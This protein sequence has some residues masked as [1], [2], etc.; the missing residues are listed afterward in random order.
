MN[1]NEAKNSASVLEGR[2]TGEAQ[3]LIE[4]ASGGQIET[5]AALLAAGAHVNA[6]NYH[7]ETALLRAA[8]GGRVEA[9]NLLL[10][11]GADLDGTSADGMTALIRAALFG[12]VAAVGALLSRGANTAI[13][14]R[15]GS[16]ALD[17]ALSKGHDDVATLI[18]NN[19]SPVEEHVSSSASPAS[20]VWPEFSPAP[21]ALDLTTET[22]KEQTREAVEENETRS[23]NMTAET[24]P[25]EASE[26]PSLSAAATTKQTRPR[27]IVVDPETQFYHKKVSPPAAQAL[28]E[29][30]A[31]RSWPVVVTILLISFV[32]GAVLY[33]LSFGLPRPSL[34]RNNAAAPSPQQPT[35]IQ[36]TV[37]QVDNQSRNGDLS[38]PPN[39]ANANILPQQNTATDQDPTAPSTPLTQKKSAAR[40]ASQAG[41]QTLSSRPPTERSSTRA[42]ETRRTTAQQQPDKS[43]ASE[44]KSAPQQQQRPET[45][46]PPRVV[47]PVRDTPARTT[48]GGA[49]SG[50][51]APDFPEARKKKVIQ[52]P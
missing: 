45:P 44:S 36:P 16:T 27:M 15:F 43:V 5:I 35:Q 39:S 31:R 6:P 22:I 25:T 28:S 19:V 12:H 48:R 20:D 50:T 32:T 14:D 9:I 2:E 10:D 42:T 33:A 46:A 17:W 51:P 3:G 8:S 38:S 11:A 52:W 21:F 26:T 18:K 7:G 40:N 24:L 37:N 47:L 29:P 34:W 23:E 4:A 30:R 1:L 41:S 49:L 13:R